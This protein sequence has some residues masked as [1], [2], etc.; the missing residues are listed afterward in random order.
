MN[1]GFTYHQSVAGQ[2]KNGAKDFN[3]QKDLV[4]TGDANKFELQTNLAGSFLPTIKFETT[5]Q[6]NPIL[7]SF[8]STLNDLSVEYTHTGPM[9]DFTCNWKLNMPSSR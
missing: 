1:D 2:M 7:L 4:F 8:K 5:W 3:F 6:Y 9:N